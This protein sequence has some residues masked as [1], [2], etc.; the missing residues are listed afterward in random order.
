M[1]S[2]NK[3]LVV[4]AVHQSGM[5]LLK[6]QPNFDIVDCDAISLRTAQ[7]SAE[8]LNEAK[9]LKIISRHGVGY[10]NI[11]LKKAKEK[12]IKIAI[13]A[14]A[15]AV[16]VAEIQDDAV[17]GAKLADDIEISTT[18]TITSTAGSNNKITSGGWVN[19]DNSGAVPYDTLTESGTNL[20]SVI[21]DGSAVAYAK[22]N[23][24]DLEVG[25]I[26]RLRVNITAHTSGQNPQFSIGGTTS[27]SKYVA[28][29][30]IPSSGYSGKG[31]VDIIFECIDS[32]MAGTNAD[33][34]R[35]WM[36]NNE[37]TNFVV[38]TSVTEDFLQK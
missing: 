27:A 3:I 26:Y 9:K 22:T 6:N 15:N 23:Y 11:D 32:D 33:S 14:N 18:G 1:S 30:A 34:A 36:Y 19:G 21:S 7:L 12:D 17:T 13:T 25:K 16:T 31:I 2:K 20:S 10:D 8:I 38:E 24:L 35:V 37:A 28:Q 4:Q 5:D 29:Q